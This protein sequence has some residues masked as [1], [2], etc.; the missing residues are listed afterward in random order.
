MRSVIVVPALALAGCGASTPT[1]TV[2]PGWTL[3]DAD[4]SNAAPSQAQVGQRGVQ[5]LDPAIHGC[6]GFAQLARAVAAHPG[7]IPAGVDLRVYA[8]NRCE[9]GASFAFPS[10]VCGDLGAHP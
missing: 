4:A 3:C 10:Q 5:D 9:D 7:A 2:E 1:P 8:A 6:A